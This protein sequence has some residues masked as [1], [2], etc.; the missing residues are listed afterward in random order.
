MAAFNKI[1]R[2]KDKANTEETGK[3][4]EKLILS[5]LCFRLL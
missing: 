1:K 4:F 3:N 2:P 5:E